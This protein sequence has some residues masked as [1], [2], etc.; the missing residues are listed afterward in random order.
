M[1]K[2]KIFMTKKTVKK[3]INK[4]LAGSLKNLRS[5]LELSQYEFAKALGLDQAA[6]SRIENA[7]QTLGLYNLILL[8]ERY[9]AA[10]GEV[11]GKVFRIE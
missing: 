10:C 11:L 2:S 4:A 5:E 8:C 3:K 9:G 6:Y 1:D 7:K